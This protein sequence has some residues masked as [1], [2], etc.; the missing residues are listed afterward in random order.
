M[1]D[2][3]ERIRQVLNE[4]AAR[5]PRA[6]RLPDRLVP[7]VRKR[8]AYTGVGVGVAIATAIVLV[9]VG[10]RAVLPDHAPV[11]ALGGSPRAATVDGVTISYPDGW[12]LT[13][14][15]NGGF[16]ERGTTVQGL[17]GFAFRP[18]LQ[19]TNFDPTAG[20]HWICP[21]ASGE[22]PD[23]GVVLYVQAVN[24]T[25]DAGQPGTWPVEPSGD[26]LAETSFGACSL[27]AHAAAWTA[28]D[29]TYEAFLTGS[30]SDYDRLVETFRSMS[31]AGGTPVTAG[32]TQHELDWSNI[33]GSIVATGSAFDVDWRV[34]TDEPGIALTIDGREETFAWGDVG[35]SVDRPLFADSNY[36][37]IALVLTDLDVDRVCVT[38]EGSWCGGWLPARDASGDEAR[39]WVIELPGA[40]T[41]PLMFD[42]R[43][44]G[45]IAWP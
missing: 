7:R 1:S 6:E 5:A 28:N 10:V 42:D 16:A 2:L 44:A 13:G 38:A 34:A 23:G 22:I 36:D 30:G 26:V 8:Q 35:W 43:D 14:L 25:M 15:Q 19:L 17:M 31:F 9:A 24:R 12:F 3:E 37:A 20:R 18:V 29:V 41:G 21:L 4:D 40:G 45:S 27:G 11:L 33:D 39:L 32:S